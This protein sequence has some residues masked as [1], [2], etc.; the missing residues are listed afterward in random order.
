MLSPGGQAV[1]AYEIYD[2]LKDDDPNLQMAA[3]VIRDGKVV[4]QSPF[5][6]VTAS[7]KTDRQDARDSG[8]RSAG[9]GP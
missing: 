8:C 4:Y 2:G 1:Y 6:P 9:A 7:P 3:A 5:T